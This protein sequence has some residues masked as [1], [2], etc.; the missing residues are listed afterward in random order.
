MVQTK[1]WEGTNF[2]VAL[3]MVILSFF[4]GGSGAE[5]IAQ[6]VVTTA[7]GGISA[8]FMVRNFLVGAKWNGFKATFADANTWNY[9]AGVVLTILPQATD[10]VPALHGV[11]DALITGNW[12][13]VISRGI[14]MLT[15]I[16][17]LFVKKPTPTQ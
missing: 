13:L 16:Y 1:F 9:I 15:I 5:G 11:Y 7:F 8:F 3:L 10:L 17:Y 14:S 12:G 6:T 4:G 2:W